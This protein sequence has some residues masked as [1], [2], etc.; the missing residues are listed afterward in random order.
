ML[1][2][3]AII[4]GWFL[5][6]MAKNMHDINLLPN[7]GDGLVTQFLNWALTI[8]R[9]LI[10]L[11]ETLAL[12]TFVY[13]FSLD[14]RIVDLHDEIKAKSAIVRNF[15]PYEDTFRNFQDRLALAKKYETISTITPHLLRD[16]IQM[17]QGVV[18]FR[19]VL[20]A[21]DT[22]KVEVQ[23]P[24]SASLANFVASLK[25]Y[26]GVLSVS[27]DKVENKTSSASIVVG[28]TAYLTPTHE[29]EEVAPEDPRTRSEEIDAIGGGTQQ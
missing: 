16:V 15:K 18:T 3:V 12:G 24:S 2:V 1:K 4:S 7:R 5:V 21:D 14:M 27:V 28:I 13:R 20:I 6:L 25:Q 11:T 26:P 8:G 22:L 19:T 9:L 23:A 17:G 10:I 29:K